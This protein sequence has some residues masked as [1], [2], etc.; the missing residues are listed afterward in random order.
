MGDPRYVSDLG[1]ILC[2]LI[3]QKCGNST[4]NTPRVMPEH[5]LF[6]LWRAHRTILE[7]LIDRKVIQGDTPIPTLDQFI[8]DHTNDELECFKELEAVYGTDRKIAVLY[9]LDFNV[10][11]ATVISIYR[12]MQEDDVSR[13]IVVTRGKVTS[14]AEAAIRNLKTQKC[15]I[16]TFTLLELQINVTHHVDVPRHIICSNEKKQ[17]VLEQYAITSDQVPKISPTDPVAR[18]FGA[19]RGQMFKVIR[20]YCD[21]ELQPPAKT[22]LVYIAYLLTG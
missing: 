1:L 12:K 13:A 9:P 6:R 4:T 16:E 8:D 5:T 7:M 17:K 21:I 15:H 10:G 3:K 18:Y 22:K 11:S 19:V 20:P 14:Y 2:L